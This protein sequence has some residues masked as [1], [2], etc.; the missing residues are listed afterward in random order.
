M[1]L[2][3]TFV[4]APLLLAST[5]AA[6]VIFDQIGGDISF[7]DNQNTYAGQHFVASGNQ[8]FNIAAV[9]QFQ[10]SGG[11]G[12]LTSVSA[13]IGMWNTAAPDINAIS[14]WDVH[15]Y[16]SLTEPDG[17]LIGNN[18]LVGVAPVSITAWGQNTSG[19]TNYLVTFDIAGMMDLADGDYWIGVVGHNDFAANG[20]IGVVGST[21]MDGPSATPFGHQVNPNGGFAFGDWQQIDPAANL[22]Y[23]IEATMIPAPGALAMLGLAGLITARRRRA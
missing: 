2:I 8:G 23:R 4:F 12:S 5:S 16:S 19:N 3:A 15:V 21:L 13:V 9:E 18:S 22:A 10:V 17:N 11:M 20:Q 14:S 6:T 1:R 7:T